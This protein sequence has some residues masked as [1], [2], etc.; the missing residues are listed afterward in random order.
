M[1]IGGKF[2]TLLD[3][4]GKKACFLNVPFP[5]AYFIYGYSCFSITIQSYWLSKSF[6]QISCIRKMDGGQKDR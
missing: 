5:P 2:S 1:R 6:Y 4:C 3:C